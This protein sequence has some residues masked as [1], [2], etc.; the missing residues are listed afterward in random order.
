MVSAL[1]TVVVVV[2]IL[3]AIVG[4][5]RTAPFIEEPMKSW[6]CWAICVIGLLIIVVTLLPLAGVHV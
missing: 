5:I 1:I 2:L 4:I 3:A 6:A